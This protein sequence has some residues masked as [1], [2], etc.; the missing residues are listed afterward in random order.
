V[1]ESTRTEQRELAGLVR[2]FLTDHSSETQV[3]RAMAGE[4]GWDPAA[5][6]IAAGQLGLAGLAV[7]ERYGGSGLG[8]V[9]LGTCFEEMGRSLFCAPMLGS[10][11]LAVH[12][13]LATGDDDACAEYLPAIASGEL[14]AAVAL[15]ESAAEPATARDIRV[16]AEPHGASWAIRGRKMFVLDGQAARL[17][18]VVARAG[19]ELGVFAVSA[20]AAEPSV[21]RTA[22]ATLDQTRRMAHLEFR[23]AP[24]RLIGRSEDTWDRLES[25]L[26]RTRLLLAAEQVGGTARVLEMAVEY[27]GQRTQFGRPIGS[28]QAVK[29]RCADM[30][31]RLEAARSAAYDG[32][33]QADHGSGALAASASLAKAYC[34]EA[35]TLSASDNVHVHG[36][37]G[38]TWEHPAQLY[39]KRAKSTEQLFGSP[40]HHRR[41]LAR[42]IWPP[43]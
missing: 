10:S 32:L 24:A 33:R 7:P 38:V 13:L 30:L 12:L 31:V 11:G 3:R 28:Y 2:S 22:I 25:A 8:P 29:H 6:S 43:R 40:A 19:D 42:L 9:E 36:G 15:H 37:I 1:L 18:L 4:L 21:E 26:D 35:Y 27:A 39:L 20:G 17:L 5:W 34:S 23:S 41:R 14:V 16:L